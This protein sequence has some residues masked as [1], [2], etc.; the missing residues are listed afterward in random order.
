MWLGKCD[1]DQVLIQKAGP[2][3]VRVPHTGSY[4]TGQKT[5]KGEACWKK[6]NVSGSALL[7]VAQENKTNLRI[8]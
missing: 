1:A 6:K 5:S 2:D 4:S 7:L 8:H 3:V